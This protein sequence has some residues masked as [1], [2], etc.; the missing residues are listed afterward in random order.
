M[1]LALAFLLAAIACRAP[2]A[3]E[4][5][6]QCT[7]TPPPDG[8]SVVHLCYRPCPPGAQA[9]AAGAELAYTTEYL[10]S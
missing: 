5:I 8:F 3:P 10:C 6:A 7:L 2:T 9:F 1:R 4:V